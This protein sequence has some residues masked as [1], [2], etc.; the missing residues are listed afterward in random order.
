VTA[1]IFTNLQEGEV[2]VWGVEW[3]NGVLDSGQWLREQKEGEMVSIHK[4]GGRQNT[5]DYRGV[6]LVGVFGKA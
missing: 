5:S 3:A 4:K 2:E 1:E 6:V